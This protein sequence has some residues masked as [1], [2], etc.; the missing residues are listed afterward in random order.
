[1]EVSE[2]HGVDRERA[3]QGQGD[4]QLMDRF[5]MID[6]ESGALS[7]IPDDYYDV[8]ILSHVIE[9]LRDGLRVLTQLVKKL[10]P[11]GVIYV[12]TPSERTLRLPSAIGFLN[13][14]DDPTHKRLYSVYEMANTLMLNGCKVRSA[15]VRRDW[16]RTVLLSPIAVA[17]NIFYYLPIRRKFFGSGLW[18]ALGVAV[19]VCAVK[20]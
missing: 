3:E 5:F 16:A 20:A 8:I 10:R 12:E 6:L 4:Y 18:D 9:H 15:G 19:F 2:Y 14:H 17:L 13:F 11:G 1:L 7:D